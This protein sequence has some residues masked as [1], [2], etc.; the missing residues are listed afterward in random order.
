MRRLIELGYA[1]A[2]LLVVYIAAYICLA[3]PQPHGPTPWSVK[4]HYRVG[5]KASEA[6]FAILEAVDRTA[7]PDRW[8]KK[9]AFELMFGE[10]RL[11]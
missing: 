5:G 9:R 3:D 7:F 10:L 8:S 11:D 2:I 4:A 6:I 1:I